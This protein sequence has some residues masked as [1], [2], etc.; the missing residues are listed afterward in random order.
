MAL[1]DYQ[2]EAGCPIRDSHLV[3]GGR[4]G[5]DALLGAP[6]MT[7]F[8]GMSGIECV[9]TEATFGGLNLTR[10]LPAGVE[11]A[12]PTPIAQH[13]RRIHREIVPHPHP[14][15]P[16]PPFSF[17]QPFGRGF[18]ARFS[19]FP[20]ILGS[21]SSG[22]FA[23]SFSALR[24]K[25][26]VYSATEPSAGNQRRLHLCKRRALFFHAR[27]RHHQILDVFPQFA[28]NL[29][30]QYH[31]GLL[32]TLIRNVLN[33]AHRQPRFLQRMTHG[34]NRQLRSHGPDAS[35]GPCLNTHGKICR[36]VSF[37]HPK[38]HHTT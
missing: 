25:S 19:S 27:P 7:R 2:A 21:T 26:T 12:L 13:H 22:S 28:M 23:S 11:S 18:V 30:V 35:I 24:F 32:P 31:R 14:V 4:S 10:T 15:L 5:T 16:L 17:S 1:K 6:L 3:T 9:P 36:Q 34:L 38:H 37:H 29:Q 8:C 33:T 20:T